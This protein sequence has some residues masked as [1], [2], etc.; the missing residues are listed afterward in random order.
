M[1]YFSPSRFHILK[2]LSTPQIPAATRKQTSK[3]MNLWKPFFHL[4]HYNVFERRL[5]RR[6]S[7]G[8]RQIVLALGTGKSQI[9]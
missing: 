8:N 5:V 3:Y 6:Q 2:V 4:N 1:T 9:G 7:I